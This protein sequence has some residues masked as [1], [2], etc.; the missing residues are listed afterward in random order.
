MVLPGRE[1]ADRPEGF[2]FLPDSSGGTSILVVF[3]TPAPSRLKGKD[4]V[5]ADVYRLK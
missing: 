5:L 3:D 2:T 4:A 1:G